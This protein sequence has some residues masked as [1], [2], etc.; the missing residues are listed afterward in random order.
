MGEKFLLEARRDQPEINL[1][2]SPFHPARISFH[3]NGRLSEVFPS[4][5]YRLPQVTRQPV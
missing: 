5:Y 3:F 1:V 2:P 4:C